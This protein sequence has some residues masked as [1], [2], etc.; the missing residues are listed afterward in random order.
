MQPDEISSATSATIVRLRRDGGKGRS[1]AL[2][3][4]TGEYES[5]AEH[6]FQALAGR[7]RAL[8]FE[9]PP[10]TS[11]NWRALAESLIALLGELKVRQASFVAFGGSAALAQRIAIEE[12]R[13]MRT[14][15]L[16]D[17]TTRPHPTSRDRILDRL[18][19]FFP[20]GLPLRTSTPGFDGKPYLQRMRCP[21]LIVTSRRR[22]PFL[23]AQ[24]ALMAEGMPTS[25]LK[26]LQSTAEPEELASLVLEFQDVPAKCP[27]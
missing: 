8:I 15:V 25:W 27:Q 19:R 22:T 7:T 23:E 14:M 17:A 2:V 12:L 9:S 1:V 24:A 18:E 4:E 10:V 16:V 21:A 5:F 11:A 26:K 20:L 6:L 13:L 3:V